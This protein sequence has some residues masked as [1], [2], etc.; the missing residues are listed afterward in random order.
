MGKILNPSVQE[1]RRHLEQKPT[2]ELRDIYLLQNEHRWSDEAV[3]AIR[4]ILLARGALPSDL[5]VSALGEP[6]VELTL[7]RKNIEAQKHNTDTY[8]V[9]KT[10]AE[11][12]W[13]RR[14]AYSA[15]NSK[16]RGI[17]GWLRLFI[18][19]NM[20]VGPVLAGIHLIFTLIGAGLL[21]SQYP[22]LVLALLIEIGGS[23]CFTVWGIRVSLGLRDIHPRAVQNAKILLRY[24]A[25][26]VT[27]SPLITGPLSG[28]PAKDLVPDYL[29]NAFLT[30]IGFAIWYPYFSV[31]KRVKATYPDA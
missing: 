2:A 26:W 23:I 21:A 6:E 20:Y 29:R 4:E 27:L 7:H 10:E 19:M 5:S 24:T 11:T 9:A 28:L 8:L 18:V 12:I 13:E 30:L 22:N 16:L 1:I 15:A 25:L 31:S 14:P 17:G 3:R